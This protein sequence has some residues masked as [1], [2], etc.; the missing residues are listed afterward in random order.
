MASTVL[1]RCPQESDKAPTGPF[2]RPVSVYLCFCPHTPPEVF[3]RCNQVESCRELAPS[4][5][6]PAL[7][8]LAVGLAGLL[9]VSDSGE[10]SHWSG[11]PFRDARVSHIL[12][13]IVGMTTH[14]FQERTA[15]AA[16]APICPKGLRPSHFRP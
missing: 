6:A 9:C 13:W 5:K 12:L 10:T 3:K 4:N 8:S 1:T 7:L 15:I 11:H 16:P 2:S 14:G